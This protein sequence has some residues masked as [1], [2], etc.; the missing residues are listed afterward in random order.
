MSQFLVFSVLAT[1]LFLQ[2]IGAQ[3]DPLGDTQMLRILRSRKTEQ[4]EAISRSAIRHD[5][6]FSDRFQASRINFT[7]SIVE[8]ALKYFKPAHYDHGTGLAVADIDGD[9]FIDI[10]FVN[11][12]GGSQLWRNLGEGRFQNITSQAGVG[13]ADRISV[14]A[15]FADI[16]NDGDPD[17]FVTSV[18]TGNTLFENLGNG[19]FRDISTEAGVDYKGHSSGATFFDVN[20]D[21]LLDLLVSNVGIYTSHERGLGGYYRALPDAFSG[22][23]EPE[24]GETSLLYI[25]QGRRR[26]KESAAEF[27]LK[28]N[29]FNGDAAFADVN[30]DGFLDLY[31]A[32][33]QGDDLFFLNNAGK[34]FTEATTKFFPKTPWGAMGVN[35]ADF[36]QD[37]L[38]DLFVTDMHSDMTGMQTKLSKTKADPDFETAKSEQWCI[39]EY[40]DAY[41]NN[42]ANN[43]FGNALY[44][45]SAPG[46]FT[47]SS[48]AFAAETFWPWGMS[49]GDVNADGYP[50]AFIT[51]GMGYGFRYGI[52]SLLLND[53][54]KT[55]AHAEF[56]T[57]IEP[58]AGNRMRKHAFTLDC[59]GADKDHPLCQ[60]RNGTVSVTEVLSARSS[61]MFDLDNDGDL[62]L[63]V[64]EM[65]DRPQILVSSLAAHGDISWLKVKLRGTKS[66]RDGL[67]ARIT[68][69][70][71]GRTWHAQ[72]DGKSGYLAQSSFPLYFGLAG[73]RQ[74][75]S[76]EIH[77]PS[78]RKQIMARV[79]ANQIITA[80]E[81]AE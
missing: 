42:S 8:D 59:S 33:M 4:I 69:T 61:A 75:D 5:F 9:S 51:A 62:D 30:R 14:A 76:L 58:R 53:S 3:S 10:Y 19:R 52:N 22:H 67:G 34:S 60:G 31:L 64:N 7:N 41:L 48:A 40:T 74:I 66:N 17:L 21:G 24:R 38:F 57:G 11:Q 13:L 44:L 29:A 78:G 68:L 63:V 80:D 70:A 32:N 36:N 26:F 25:N 20:N 6:S 23:T 46:K 15:S 55:F 79:Q 18:R 56:V 35:F 16:D 39:A 77:W 43:I 37:G 2:S 49:V 72:I 73:V 28:E 1:L 27:G 54:G 45:A 12:I 81:P 71:G 47:E 50:D 65:D